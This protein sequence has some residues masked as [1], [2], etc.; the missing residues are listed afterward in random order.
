MEDIF[1]DLARKIY[2]LFVVN[3]YAVAIQQDDGSYVTKYVPYDYLL[4][5]CMLER[6]GAAGCYQ[7]GFKNGLIK[8]ICL[9]F[10]CKDKK[11]PQ[12]LLLY[13]M[14]KSKVLNHLEILG[15]RYLTEF[16]GRRGIHV[17]I[18]FTDVFPKAIGFEMVNRIVDVV[19]WD[20]EIFGLDVFPATD[21][22]KGN[23]VG[24][25]VKF[26]LSC[27]KDGGQSFLFEGI[28]DF[29]CIY[30]TDF[31]ECQY[32]LLC[33][34]QVN[35]VNIVSKKLGVQTID[36]WTDK[37]KYK[38][39]YI[40]ENIRCSVYDIEQILGET[41]VFHTIFKRLREGTPIQRDWFVLLGTLGAID[42]E[43][44][45]LKSIFSRSPAYDEEITGKNILKWKNKYYPATFSYL[46]KIYGL[47]MESALDPFQTGLEY[48]VKR[49]D[50]KYGNNLEYEIINQ[51]KNEK[52]SCNDVRKTTY[53]EK[54]YLLT[55][56]ENIVISVWNALNNL[57]EYDYVQ[58]RNIVDQI[59]MGEIKTFDK[60]EFYR[61]VREESDEKQR[62]LVVLGAYDRII[63]TQLAMI[64]AYNN[65]SLI[66][67]FSYNVAFLSKEDIFYNWYTSWGNYIEKIKVFL[68]IPYLD[69]WG[70]IVLD[71]KRFYDNINFLTVYNTIKDN[72]SEEDKRI[73]KFLIKYNEELM[74]ELTGGRLGVPQ[75]P[76]Y[77][78]IVSEMF[79]DRIL[80]KLSK[81][82]M[83]SSHYI[84]YRYVDDIIVFYE[85]TIDGSQLY[86]AIY[87]LLVTNGLEVNAAKSK[88]YGKIAML[89]EK[90]R[91]D[92]L[93]KEKFNYMLQ[94]S[95]INALL[96]EQEKYVIYEKCISEKFKIE[97]VAFVFSKKTN[98]F[99]IQK[100]FHRYKKEIFSSIYGRGSIFLR[101]YQFV[102]SNRRFLIEAV[103][104]GCFECIKL[105]SLNFKNCISSMYYSV[106]N[107]AI[108]LDMFEIICNTFLRK[109]EL[110][111]IDEEDRVTIKSL[112]RWEKENA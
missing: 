13:S 46:Y 53:K 31:Y 3:P 93:R 28:P 38:K 49:M 57:T 108:D 2:E 29:E 66:N 61:F 83:E 47:E 76:A 87:D 101:F 68:E 62:E 85:P 94:D 51:Q 82:E 106:Q 73:F 41:Q 95:D 21:S 111:D 72:L 24:K 15:I 65:S 105:D 109:I 91:N 97:D 54:H 44:E 90:N 86:N 77:A 20:N 8:W 55:N 40:L 1:S 60:K 81:N 27:H 96:T 89:S 32:K 79:I 103:E 52:F 5:K 37:I 11:N 36:N 78:R 80:K 39:I 23:K 71:I 34:Y 43:G 88:L 84:L 100:Y 18:L 112:L 48:L 10:D 14:I 30:E 22:S 64:L 58:M 56:D 42:R 69:N 17:W 45:I 70:I 35:D 110:E 12:I 6:K 63:T 16:S 19:G 67:S 59:I 99:Y 50:E 26:P 33:Q 9:D 4:L 102:F 92:I 107:K 74:R 7:Q 75:G 25:Q 104:T 98:E